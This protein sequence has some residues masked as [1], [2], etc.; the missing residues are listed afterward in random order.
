MWVVVSEAA[1]ACDTGSCEVRV[2]VNGGVPF[3][4]ARPFE[5]AASG[6]ASVT[7]YNVTAS[8]WL[9][10]VMIAGPVQWVYEVF[11]GG[12]CGGVP[13]WRWLPVRCSVCLPCSPSSPLP[14]LLSCADGQLFL[15][16]LPLP[17]STCAHCAVVYRGATAGADV[18]QQR[19][20]GRGGCAGLRL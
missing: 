4:A 9:N 19:H 6:A 11:P 3:T 2:A 14:T 10:S 15:V 18:H 7:R 20:R 8:T 12:T 1:P 16:F 5:L 17:F 13:H